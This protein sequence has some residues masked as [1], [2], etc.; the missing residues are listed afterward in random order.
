MTDTHP[1][2]LQD[3]AN[4]AAWRQAMTSDQVTKRNAPRTA[5]NGPVAANLPQNVGNYLRRELER[6]NGALTQN[7]VNQ[8]AAQSGAR[9]GLDTLIAEQN[10]L[11]Q[12]KTK[13]E[14][15]LNVGV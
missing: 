1:H 10:R 13:L 2:P 12:E 14:Y 7:A 5:E 3:S 9:R 8:L 11:V 15:L 4:R 6:V